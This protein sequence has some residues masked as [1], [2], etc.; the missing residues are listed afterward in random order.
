M[1][2]ASSPKSD[3][4]MGKP[5]SLL[6]G[7]R[8]LS[9]STRGCVHIRRPAVYPQ[10]SVPSPWSRSACAVSMNNRSSL[11]RNSASI[12]SLLLV[13]ILPNKHHSESVI[14]RDHVS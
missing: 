2:G 13:S 7:Q 8:L 3:S 5:G 1:A 6:N 14:G 4:G 12:A 10:N 9:E 11:L